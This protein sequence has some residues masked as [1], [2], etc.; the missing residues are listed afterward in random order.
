MDLKILLPF[1]IFAEIKNVS[2]IVFD[3]SEGSYGLLP[4]RLDCVAALV[5]GI[6]TYE[7]EPGGIHYLAVDQGVLVKA[8]TQVLVSVRNAIGGAD[9]GKLHEL[10]EREFID[11]DESEKNV[12]FVMAKMESGF[13]YNF[14]KFRKE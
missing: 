3:T 13:I 14:E 12:R 1:R 11:L 10:V 8:N 5:P 2:R 4:Q 6:F 7:T 9:L